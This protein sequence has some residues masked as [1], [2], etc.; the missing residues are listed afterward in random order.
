MAEVEFWELAGYPREERD[1]VGFVA[2]RKLLV[3]WRYRDLLR[4][5]LISHPGHLYPYIADHQ[6]RCVKVAVEPLG[7]QTATYSGLAN[8]DW[9]V[10]T[11]QYRTPRISDP[12]PYP[13]SQ[14][15]T[16]Y[17]QATATISETIEPF[18]EA[19]RLDY[20]LFTWS[21]DTELKPDEA[22]VRIVHRM[23]YV[24]T[25]HYLADAMLGTISSLVGKINA[26]EVTPILLSSDPF[27]AQTL[28]F[29]PAQ[30]RLSAND[31]GEMRIDVTMRFAYKEEG[32]RKFWRG[33]TQQ[34][35]TL[36]VK[37]SGNAYNIP[38]EADF[39]VVFP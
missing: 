1:V 19:Q 6:A 39:S 10:V 18:S 3:E 32:W 34:Y 17:A 12:Q 13:K 20:Q 23:T 15:P 35:D 37:A 21:D 30:T 5:A 29:Q 4:E 7:K 14:S 38:E 8:Y 22:P 27:P 33:D 25:R 28:L 31:L 26:A 2:T 9:A 16:K 24:L 36:K 11:A